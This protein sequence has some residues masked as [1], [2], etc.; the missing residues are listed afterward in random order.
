LVHIIPEKMGYKAEMDTGE[1]VTYIADRYL[2]GVIFG[3]SS[4]VVV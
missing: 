2:S 1:M 3:G 4:N